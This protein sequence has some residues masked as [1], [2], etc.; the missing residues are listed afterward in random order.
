LHLSSEK[1]VSKFAFK[2]VNLYR[3]R[4][5]A[6]RRAR[7]AARGGRGGR[8]A[9]IGHMDHTTAVRLVTWTI[10]R[11]SS[12]GA[13]TITRLSSIGVLTITR[14]SLIGVL[15]ITLL[16]S[17]GVLTITR[18][19]SIGVLTIR[20]GGG[21]RGGGAGHAVGLCTLNQVDP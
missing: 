5:E 17:I 21:A 1:P 2:W 16:S 8:G 3:Y 11:L 9:W 7:G 18:L 13:L 10:T 12:I 14:L 6:R 19:S 15:T 4:A 20:G